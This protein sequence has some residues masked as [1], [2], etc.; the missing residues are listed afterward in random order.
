MEWKMMKYLT[1]IF[2]C[3]PV[4]WT[5]SST[6]FHL[7]EAIF[8]SS[9]CFKIRCLK[10]LVILPQTKVWNVP[11]FSERLH[12]F[13]TW[14]HSN[15]CESLTS[16]VWTTS[17]RLVSLIIILIT[18]S[19]CSRMKSV[20]TVVNLSCALVSVRWQDWRICSTVRL[21][22]RMWYD[23]FFG[24]G[25]GPRHVSWNH[26]LWTFLLIRLWVV[27]HH[28]LLVCG[29]HLDVVSEWM[30]VWVNRC[31][32]Y[33]PLYYRGYWSVPSVHYQNPGC[34]FKYSREKKRKKANGRVCTA[35]C[36][37]WLTRRYTRLSDVTQ[38]LC[39]CWD[40]GPSCLGWI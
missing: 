28:R 29:K 33:Q 11:F 14:M 25:G 32:T 7:L 6:V 27:Y 39:W 26:Y 5:F 21:S 23:F 10:S 24:W 38:N 12:Y 20:E 36:L 9:M 31:S 4:N 16:N 34:T 2:S 15:Q 35:A 40:V 18:S 19:I 8:L 13:C 1:S 37:L 30:C 3:Q 22:R 17:P